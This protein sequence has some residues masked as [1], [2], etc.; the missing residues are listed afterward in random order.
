MAAAAEPM[1]QLVA[2]DVHP[3]QCADDPLYLPLSALRL[4]GRLLCRLRTQVALQHL[5][6]HTDQPFPLGL[7][8][9]LPKV[10]G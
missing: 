7:R 8:Q 10:L 6:E 5:A 4:I 1:G 2:S 9:T 3:G